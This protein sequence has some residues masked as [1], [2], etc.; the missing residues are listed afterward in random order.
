MKPKKN[1]NVDEEDLKSR[2][3][4]ILSGLVLVIAFVLCLIE[5]KKIDLAGAS[6]ESSLTA[7]E[8]EEVVEITLNTPPPPPTTPPATCAS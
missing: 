3:V 7:L 8:D 6:I 2:S 5:Y 4:Y 1:N